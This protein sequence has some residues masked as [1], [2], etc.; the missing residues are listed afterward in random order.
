MRP[1][2]LAA[3]SL[4]VLAVACDDAPRALGPA[5]TIE[6]Q[7]AGFSA[8]NPAGKTDGIADLIAAQASAWADKDATAYAATYTEDAD[9]I[10]PIAGILAGRE[11]IR[12]QHAFLFNPVNGPFRASTSSWNL[13]DLIFLSGSVALVKLDVTLTGFSGLPPGLPAVEPGVVRTRVSWIAV[14]QGRE[15]RILF[16]Q[17]TP[18][19]SMN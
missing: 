8:V 19:P 5:D 1:H 15:W 12:S 18:Y 16:Q 17:M 11:V 10:N 3:A 9:L 4:L 7:S 14:R 2:P 13:R 6:T